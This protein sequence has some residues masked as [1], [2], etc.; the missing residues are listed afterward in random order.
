MAFGPVKRTGSGR[1]SNTYI[2]APVERV[3]DL[4]FPRG[5]GCGGWIVAVLITMPRYAS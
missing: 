1:R 4:R 5:R 3:E 2:G